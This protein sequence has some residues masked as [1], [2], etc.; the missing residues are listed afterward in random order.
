MG[1]FSPQFS[2]FGGNLK[3]NNF[4]DF[5]PLPE[6]KGENYEILKNNNEELTGE[7]NR[8]IGERE[9]IKE[10]HLLALRV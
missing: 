9:D 4:E 6:V 2:I 3:S 1:N 7:H 10:I 8:M 5:F